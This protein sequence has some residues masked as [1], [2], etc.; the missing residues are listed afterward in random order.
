MSDIGTLNEKPLHAAL[1]EWYARPGDRFEV[2]IDGYVVD[3]VRDDLLIEVQTGSFASIKRKMHV[4]AE[5]H[6]LRL[7]Y[8]IAQQ[9]W[10]ARLAKNGSGIVASR[11]R[12]PKRGAPEQVFRELVSFPKL[13][14]NPNF[15]MDVLLIREEE[16]RCHDGKRGWRRGGWITHERRLLDVVA[17]QVFEGP[18]DLLGFIPQNLTEFWTTADLAVALGQ[19]RW[20]AQKMVYCLR[21]IGAVRMVGKQG[22]AILYTR[23]T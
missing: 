8:P 21:E 19:P 13:I 6:L 14:V 18:A 20:L 15:S 2:S 4:L 12:S 10:I 1:K 16:V 5:N 3:I 23:G 22:N 7:V 9:K 11:R 17:C